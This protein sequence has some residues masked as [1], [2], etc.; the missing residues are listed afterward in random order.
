MLSE[1]NIALFEQ[2]KC[3][4]FKKYI[5]RLPVFSIHFPIIDIKPLRMPGFEPT[6]SKLSLC[7]LSRHCFDFCC[8]C[9][10]CYCCCCWCCGSFFTCCFVLTFVL[11]F[12]RHPKER[13]LEVSTVRRPQQRRGRRQ[14]QS[15]RQRGLHSFG[16]S[17]NV[18]NFPAN[19]VNIF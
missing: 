15:S 5:Y 12:F 4:K 7:R 10:S 18:G 13:P 9:C 2:M 17:L 3:I 1:A 16:L 8:C 14:P 6:F 11:L 19:E